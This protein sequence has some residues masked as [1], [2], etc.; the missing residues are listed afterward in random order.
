MYKKDVF[1]KQEKTY[2]QD[3][4]TKIIP[5]LMQRVTQSQD[6]NFV[7]EHATFPD[8]RV[9]GMTITFVQE[10]L[11]RAIKKQLKNKSDKH[12]DYILKLLLA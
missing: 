11:E 10:N 2:L 3:R 5:I 7:F 8:L 4:L 9:A 12:V 6:G 1:H